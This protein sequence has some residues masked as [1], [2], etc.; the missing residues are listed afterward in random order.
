MPAG[1][2]ANAAA[3]SQVKPRLGHPIPPVF[4]PFGK[5]DV[6]DFIERYEEVGI[7][8]GWNNSIFVQ[9]LA[10]SL[11]GHASGWW[12]NRPST[13]SQDWGDIKKELKD[14]FSD[15]TSVESDKIKLANRIL[16]GDE[17]T[18]QFYISVVS[19]CDKV[20]PNMEEK[21]K[22][23]FL[24]RGFSRDVR[25]RAVGISLVTLEQVRNFLK[26]VQ[27]FRKDVFGESD[28][29]GFVGV[30]K[31]GFSSGTEPDMRSTSHPLTAD[32][33]KRLVSDTM[34]EEM[35]KWK[36]S[37]MNFQTGSNPSWN[38]RHPSGRANNTDFKCYGCGKVGHIKR[39]CY[40]RFNGRNGGSIPGSGSVENHSL[41][42]AGQN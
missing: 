22:I 6:A 25:K 27:P 13:S 17:S 32:D 16:R 20:D 34:R 7:A 36:N 3:S 41:N 26:Q 30:V 8:S 11:S 33:V 23:E 15:G 29:S 31:S 28:N 39:N 19:L 42:P 18:M 21:E 9:Q 35:E 38:S 12:R 37:S 2:D 14:L 4:L 5:Q 24:I 10:L 1:A 40:Q